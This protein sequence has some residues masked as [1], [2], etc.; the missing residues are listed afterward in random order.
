MNRFFPPKKSTAEAP[1][2][3]AGVAL[4]NPPA[5]RRGVPAT[6]TP[7]A[8]FKCL[9]DAGHEVVALHGTSGDA[10]DPNLVQNARNAFE[11]RLVRGAVGWLDCWSGG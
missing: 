6:V 1:S 3:N 9:L 5:A 11:G 2:L 8:T 4:A 7:S 10:I